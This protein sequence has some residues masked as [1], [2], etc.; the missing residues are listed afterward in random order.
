MTTLSSDNVSTLDN[1]LNPETTTTQSNLPKVAPVASNVTSKNLA[2]NPIAGSPSNTPIN[3]TGN[4]ATAPTGI[5]KSN[6]TVS[7]ACDSSTYVGGMVNQIGGFGGQV[8]KA[9][10]DGIKALLTALGISPAGSGIVSQ[11]KKLASDIKDALKWIKNITDYINQFVAY[12]NAIKQLI[13]YLLTLPAR[14]LAYFK[15]CLST[16]KKQLVAGFKTAL[17]DTPDPSE[18]DISSL[19]NDIE[20]IK[21]SI[22]QAQT[23]IA[24]TVT[25]VV[26]G[27]ASLTTLNQISVGNTA[28][29]QAA[30]TEVF[31]A[32]GFSNASGNFSKA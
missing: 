2:E 12:V 27:V 1:A 19:Q 14:L 11:L 8:V 22:S 20:D 25:N 18:A 6:E 23:A 28:L 5:K 4:A 32:A 7:H 9:I 16:L 26:K 13:S 15:D 29:Q 17:S 10:R 21:N 30:T 24:G 31:A 3:A